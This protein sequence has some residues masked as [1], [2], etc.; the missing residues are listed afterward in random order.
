M[1]MFGF[2]IVFIKNN[3]IIGNVGVQ[4]FFEFQQDQQDVLCFLCCLGL[5]LELVVGGEV[6]GGEQQRGRVQV[7]VVLGFQSKLLVQGLGIQI[8]SGFDISKC[9]G[10]G[11]DLIY[12]GVKLNFSRIFESIKVQ[13]IVLKIVLYK[14]FRF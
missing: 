14:I 3:F 11:C 5:C 2:C 8:M 4:V 10:L 1:E 9:V 13:K 6:E 7:F 12:I